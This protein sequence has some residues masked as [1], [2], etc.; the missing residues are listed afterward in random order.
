MAGERLISG[1]HAC[2]IGQR[3]FSRTRWTEGEERRR[4]ALGGALATLGLWLVG[5][6]WLM[7]VTCP[8]ALGASAADAQSARRGKTSIAVLWL[9]DGTGDAEAAHW[10][11]TVTHLLQEEL[12][13]V[14]ALRLRTANALEYAFEQAKVDAG[15]AIDVAKAREIGE[16][17]EAQR[18]IWGSYHREEDQW[19]V[20][21]RI[22][23]TATG[24]LS[25][26][27]TASGTE[28]YA[29]RDGLAEQILKALKI[30]PSS[31]ERE[32]MGRR[33][34]ASSVAFEWFSRA[35]A[36]QRDHGP[37]PEQERCI[38]QA[39]VADP[40]FAYAHAALAAVLG[41]QGKFDEAEAAVHQ[42]LDLAPDF[43]PGHFVLGYL[44]LHLRQLDEAKKELIEARRLNGDDADVVAALAQL[45]WMQRDPDAALEHLHEAAVLDPFNANIRATLGLIYGS[46]QDRARALIA[47]Q[48]AEQLDPEGRDINATQMACQVYRL[49]GEIPK[50]IEGYEKFLKRARAE[51]L[52]P[53]GIDEFEGTLNR[54]K[55][56]LT[57]TFIDVSMPKVYTAESL[58][59]ALRERL[60]EGQLAKVVNPMA[61][62]EAI[63]LWARSLTK[64]ATSDLEKARALFDGLTRRIDPRSEQ[65]ARTAQEVFAA[66]DDPKESFNCQEYTKLFLALAREV[67]LKA[68][69]VHLDRD[70]AGRAVNHDCAIVF[71]EDKALMIDPAYRWFGVP[72]R[73]YVVLD[74]VQAIAHHHFQS[75]KVA[76]CE[77]A[78]RLHPN[79][80]WGQR[81]LAM[82]VLAAGQDEAAREVLQR[83]VEGEPEHWEAWRL[84][85]IFALEGGDVEAAGAHLQRAVAGNPRD[86]DSHMLLALALAEQGKP[87]EARKHARDCLR[88][89]TRPENAQA[90]RRLIA[91]INEAIGIDAEAASSP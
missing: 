34:T 14:A 27:V 25:D 55:G 42:A 83:A 47:L 49:L 16:F 69:Y 33:E 8:S 26:E 5:P 85:G 28:W 2:H 41:S 64:E 80:A 57:P 6:V 12:D 58:Q 9:E 88:H 7:L 31:G 13:R 17:V 77:L 59:E 11:Y 61:S 53:H 87:V 4:I 65:S 60:T 40:Q 66:W 38:R 68:F 30:E 71:L 46:K 48:E 67:G 35:R 74:D 3:R 91:R 62:T 79:F 37:M 39:V 15:A 18:V 20:R 24:E 73:E 50:A 23:N 21:M 56:S 76:S 82:S 81:R 72:H 52:N 89:C 45:A 10:R 75:T 63:D 78:A 29:L 44:L 36:L 1:S 54:L 86:S 90:A 51:G 32:Q 43:G 84:Q 22:L 70:H 19:Q